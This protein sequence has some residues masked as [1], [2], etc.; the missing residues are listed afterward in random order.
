MFFLKKLVLWFRVK[1]ILKDRYNLTT[2]YTSSVVGTLICKSV[3]LRNLILR[4]KL[5]HPRLTLI[6]TWW[7]DL[8]C[9]DSLFRRDLKLFLNGHAIG[10]LDRIILCG[11][12]VAERRG[13]PQH[14]TIA[15]PYLLNAP[16]G[17]V[18]TFPNAPFRGGFH[19]RWELLDC[20]IFQECTLSH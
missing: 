13:N 7:R 9:L 16:L 20:G 2:Q 3:G 10:L 1:I 6:L 4:A 14:E 17:G 12:T 15:S 18:G 11:T 5:R 8:E 19:P